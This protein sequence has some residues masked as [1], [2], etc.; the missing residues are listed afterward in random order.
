MGK[1]EVEVVAGKIVA[2]V[3]DRIVVALV[4]VVVDRIVAAALVV[5]RTVVSAVE[6]LVQPYNLVDTE[7]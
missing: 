4:V 2:L 3:V 6:S 1:I 5:G 7:S